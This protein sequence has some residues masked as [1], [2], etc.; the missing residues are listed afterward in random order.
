MS[1]LLGGVDRPLQ[2]DGVCESER[3]G[4]SEGRERRGGGA[5]PECGARGKGM[6]EM[7]ERGGDGG[8]RGAES[9][10]DQRRPMPSR[11]RGR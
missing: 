7:R 2:R 5:G 1:T 8:A 6:G 9:P 3:H 10:L 4:S 11:T